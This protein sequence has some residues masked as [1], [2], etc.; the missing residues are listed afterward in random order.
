[1]AFHALAS[2]IAAILIAPGIVMAFVPMLPALTYMF[3]MALLYAVLSGFAY[4]SVHE[5]LILLIFVGVG[6]ITDHTSGILGAKYGGAHTKS[7]LWGI[8]GAIVGVFLLPPFGA[9]IGL[10]LAILF[11]EIYFKKTHGEAL[12]AASSALVGSAIG[13]AVNVV[14]AF[15]FMG[16]FLFFVLS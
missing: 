14:L 16:T 10:F 7:L 9:F 2:T 3:A 1:M 11:A 4:L 13:V 6:F 15:G 12:K 5:I 8:L